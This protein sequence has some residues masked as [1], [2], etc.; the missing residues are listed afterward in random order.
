EHEALVDDLADLALF[1]AR[2]RRHLRQVRAGDLLQFAIDSFSGWRGKGEAID[3]R[4][5]ASVEGSANQ[6]A[7]DRDR[8][9]AGDSRDRIVDAGRDASMP[10]IDGAHDGR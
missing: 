9:K 7:K 5:H 1:Y 2:E 8:Q 3:R 4:P 6:D 10:R